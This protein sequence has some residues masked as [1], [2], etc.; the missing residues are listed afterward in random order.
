M[1]PTVEKQS[2][3]ARYRALVDAIPT[4]AVVVSDNLQTFIDNEATR[5]LF[6]RKPWSIERLTNLVQTSLPQIDALLSESPDRLELQSQFMD[7]QERLRYL[8]WEITRCEVS[9]CYYFFCYDKTRNHL[10]DEQLVATIKQLN[11]Q[12]YALDQAS[13]VAVTDSKGTISYANDKFVEISGY[14]LDE[15][16][17]QNHRILNSGIHDGDFFRNLWKTISTG[18]VWSGEICN[19][20]KQG[21][22]Y[23]VYTTI[24]PFLGE[25][26]RPYQYIA[27]RTDVTEK[28]HALKQV[29]MERVRTLHAEKMATLG[30]MAA[31][32]AHELGN[33]VA[34]IS[35]WF[36]VVANAVDQGQVDQLDLA[37][38][39]PIVRETVGRMSSIIKGMLTYARDGSKDP[40]NPVNI[41]ALVRS[42]ISYC[43]HHTKK[44]GATVRTT[45]HRQDFFC[46]GRQSDLS[47]VF[48][49]LI[50][51]ACDAIADLQQRWIRI[52]SY[53][54]TQDIVVEFSDSGMGIDDAV[55]T[56][57]M[58]PF[59]STKP[60]GQGTGLGLSISSSIVAEHGG[61][62]SLASDR[63]N[64]TFVIRL[65]QQRLQ[66]WSNNDRFSVTHHG[67]EGQFTDS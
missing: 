4:P 64:T 42:V 30:Q 53:E 10:V 18:Q 50:L 13:I 62:L 67:G 51:N 1:G 49:N 57:I 24:V 8:R 5:E 12:K 37:E 33:P 20:S 55:A 26:G 25:S 38:N 7:S 45:F 46:S 44:A 52:E 66:I 61:R 9:R 58:E 35:S 22:L 34:A 60:A 29:E 23:W 3:D 48:V 32:I 63:P 17:G 39:M 56:K 2:S 31:G 40:F 14:E 19:R 36:E 21:G 47:Q 28:K 54:D 27:I 43:Q 65:P 6:G 59:Y 15:L 41:P 11:D 16:V